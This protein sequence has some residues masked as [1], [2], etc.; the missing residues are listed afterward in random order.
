MVDVPL[1]ESK[2][3]ICLVRKDDDEN[4][5]VG[6]QFIVRGEIKHTHCFRTP[7]RL[8]GHAI[9]DVC[10]ECKQVVG[11]PANDGKQQ[12]ILAGIISNSCICA[13]PTCTCQR[14]NFGVWCARI[15]KFR[16]KRD[17]VEGPCFQDAK[18]RLGDMDLVSCYE[19][20]EK[21]TCDGQLTLT[22]TEKRAV[23]VK[24][25]SV[26]KPALLRT[27]PCKISS[28]SMHVSMGV[29]NGGTDAMRG[30]IRIL[31][32]DEPF[33]ANARSV[34]VRVEKM[35]D[36]LALTPSKEVQPIL[37]PLHKTSLKLRKQVAKLRKKVEKL[38]AKE[39]DLEN[40]TKKRGNKARKK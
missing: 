27:H 30:E 11:Y 4:I 6:I 1:D 17:G 20:Y 10:V 23:S 34:W 36:Q 18:I 2:I 3:D 33:I 37:M 26:S 13:C 8:E 28:D 35:L 31:T 5:A 7:F 21:E 32:K 14:G 29:A 38:K 40:W 24:C 39:R 16:R 25:C 9:D 22:A 15:W 19:R 12:L